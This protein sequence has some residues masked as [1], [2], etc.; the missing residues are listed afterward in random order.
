MKL[1]FEP[2]ADYW[3]IWEDGRDRANVHYECLGLIFKDE[4]GIHW[5]I[6]EKYSGIIELEEMK[7]ITDFMEKNRDVNVATGEEVKE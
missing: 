7:Q 5:N 4:L 6:A 2:E 1:R 3:L